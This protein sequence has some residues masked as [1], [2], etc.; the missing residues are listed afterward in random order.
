MLAALPGLAVVALHGESDGLVRDTA[1]V[2][3]RAE[4]GAERD[5]LRLTALRTSDER[6]VTAALR[7]VALG[8]GR[9]V[10]WAAEASEKWTE[11]ARE[12]LR[13]APAAL[14]VLG[15]GARF[16]K[17]A[18]S[19]A[20]GQHEAGYVVDCTP[21]L[22]AS[23]R[24]VGTVFAALAVTSDKG[25]VRSLVEWA[26]ASGQSPTGVA[27]RA[28]LL[29]GPGGTVDAALTARLGFDG[30]GQALAAAV[31]AG[32]GGD[33]AT[34]DR[35]VSQALHDGQNGVG[36]LRQVL[37]QVQYA[38]AVGIRQRPRTPAPGSA[39]STAVEAAAE[40]LWRAERAAKR[41][42]AP[43]ELVAAGALGW[44]ARRS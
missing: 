8:G 1:R 4:C 7:T 12:T 43:Q 23:E 26:R 29:A 19:L 2:V 5:P 10:V 28:V 38:R 32:L 3:L 40:T 6:H 22:A 16:D 13:N 34:L 42:G 18:L 44:L 37:A 39:G 30:D 35:A 17:S 9:P 25:V 27:E 36:L 14:L 33:A 20:V 21:D 15:F 11:V 41:T 24:E 31:R